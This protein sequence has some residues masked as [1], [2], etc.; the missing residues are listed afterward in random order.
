MDGLILIFILSIILAIA[1]IFLK[2]YRSLHIAFSEQQKET[3]MLRSVLDFNQTVI[4]SRLL[5]DLCH[6]SDRQT[7]G[8]EKSIAF[9]GLKERLQSVSVVLIQVPVSIQLFY[10]FH[11]SEYNDA[12][13]D[14]LCTC[15]A[16]S[17]KYFPSFWLWENPG[18]IVGI[19]EMSNILSDD[20]RLMGIHKLG[21]VLQ[22]VCASGKDKPP[23]IAFGNITSSIENLHTSYGTAAELLNHKIHNHLTLPYSYEEFQ[24][25]EVQFDYNKQQLLSRYIRLGKSQEAE[26]FLKS[27][28][29][30][31]H[32]NPNTSAASVKETANQILNVI[33]ETTKDMPATY[34]DCARLFEQALNDINGLVKVHDF[35]QLLLP[36]VQDVCGFVLAAS[37]NKGK[38]KIDHLTRWIHENYNSDLSLETM[39]ACIGCSPAY[40]SK[41]FKKETGNDIITYL[42]GVRIEHAKELLCTTQLTIAEIS[43]SVG[44][45]NQQTF[46]RNF[47]KL[48]GLTPTEYRSLPS[49]L[50][51][52]EELGAE[53]TGQK[54]NTDN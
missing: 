22:S 32:A 17:D 11:K 46:I 50:H 5:L 23:I 42:S 43:A 8:I 54:I 13:K 9:F 10:N 41:L 47:K 29:S 4:Q 15:Q 51:G 7:E 34:A 31:I 19:M 20:M 18:T 36:L 49:G 35:G 40:T 39:A 25:S 24:R 52:S 48:A 26:D 27:Y 37:A 44:F 16:A 12:Q 30:V 3:A 38:L 21:A 53:M 1:F 28:F 2:K 45:N 33:M 6:R 14:L